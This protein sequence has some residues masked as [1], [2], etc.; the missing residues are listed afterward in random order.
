MTEEFKENTLS[1]LVGNLPDEVGEN[2]PIFEETKNYKNDLLDYLIDNL[3]TVY[4]IEQTLNAYNAKEQQ[5]PY[6]YLAGFYSIN[7]QHPND[8]FI[9]VTDNKL[10]AISTIKSYSSGT[11]LSRFNCLNVGTDGKL[12]GI[13]ITNNKQRFVLLNNIV[14]DN[15]KAILRNSYYLPDNLLNY[16]FTLITKHPSEAKY[17]LCGVDTNLQPI[18]VELTINVGSENEWKVYTYNGSFIGTGASISDVWASWDSE[19]NLDFKIAG[20]NSDAYCVWYKNGDNINVKTFQVASETESFQAIR[21]QSKIIDNNKSYCGLVGTDVGTQNRHVLHYIY[22]VDFE[23][24]AIKQIYKSEAPQEGEYNS[25]NNIYFTKNNS[26]LTVMIRELVGENYTINIGLIED[27]NI[28]LHNVY[29]AQISSYL[30]LLVVNVQFNLVT[31]LCQSELGIKGLITNLVYNPTDYNGNAYINRRSLIPHS[32]RIYN[33]SNEIIFARNLYN[34]IVS[35]NSTS[36]TLQMP[37]DYC[38]GI[39]IAGENL[40]SE[41]NNVL[42]KD[43]TNLTTNIYEAVNFNFNNTINMINN[44]STGV[45]NQIGANRLNDSISQ[46][47]DYTSAKIG[48]LQLLFS[49]GSSSKREISSGE[50]EKIDNKKYRFSFTVKVPNDKLVT[51]ASLISADNLTIYQTIDLLNLKNGKT[52]NITQDVRIE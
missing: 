38:N 7:E 20:I 51:Q 52:Y 43:N 46:T 31:I 12:Y 34:V 16:D 50:W 6:V 22:R 8:Q 13:D 49:D 9:V 47:T 40:L 24:N 10:K 30:D 11:P 2:V 15:N 1:Y 39:E 42:V 21:W 5:L 23:N 33:S 45:F 27:D 44:N 3:S 4:G 35:D 25:F 26:I 48:T 28:Y 36:S 18:A 17:L 19:G 32:A 41:N 37:N 29:Q 14:A